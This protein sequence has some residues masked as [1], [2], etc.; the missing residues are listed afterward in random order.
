[1]PEFTK[2]AVAGYGTT[3]RFSEQL[4]ELADAVGIP[5]LS[6][7]GKLLWKEGVIER[8]IIETKIPGRLNDPEAEEFVYEERYPDW[9]NIVEM[10][11]QGAI[12]RI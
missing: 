5:K 2:I 11:M 12:A 4:A 3:M 6:F 7:R 8:W 10:A 9:E 1:M